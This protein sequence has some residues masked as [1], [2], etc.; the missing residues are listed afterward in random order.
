MERAFGDTHDQVT[1]HHKRKRWRDWVA[2]VG[3]HLDH[4]G[5]GPYPWSRLDQEPEII[6]ALQ[7]LPQEKHTA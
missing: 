7:T 6:A 3:R 4:N 2:E 1:R 5:P